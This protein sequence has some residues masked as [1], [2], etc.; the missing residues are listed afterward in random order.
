MYL[1]NESMASVWHHNL[2]MGP[3]TQ[4]LYGLATHNDNGEYS[5]DWETK[6]AAI[7]GIV[8]RVDHIVSQRLRK[9]DKY[10]TFME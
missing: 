3:R 2:L 1:A 4:T 6:G 8:G 5:L 7:M 9:E 10:V